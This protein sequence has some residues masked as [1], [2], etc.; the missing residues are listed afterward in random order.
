MRSCIPRINAVILKQFNNHARFFFLPQPHDQRLMPM[1]LGPQRPRHIFRA[2]HNTA[3]LVIEAENRGHHV[4]AGGRFQGWGNL[5][6][7]ADVPGRGTGSGTKAGCK[8]QTAR[9]PSAA[10]V[11]A[12]QGGGLA[13]RGEDAGLLGVPGSEA[14]LRN[15][16]LLLHSRL[17]AQRAGHIVEIP[18]LVPLVGGEGDGFR[19][20][21]RQW[22][23][24][25]LCHQRRFQLGRQL[26]PT[27]P[28]PAQ[29]TQAGGF[30]QIVFAGRSVL[31]NL[32]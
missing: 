1:L 10:S 9:I 21:S 2:G 8:Q 12:G 16:G 15:E 18:Y 11:R 14:V 23:Q 3:A 17:G 29:D 26:L 7:I 30:A 27:F 5:L 22:N 25:R 13:L 6:L 4:S 20:R 32:R 24:P 19:G 28:R 31:Q